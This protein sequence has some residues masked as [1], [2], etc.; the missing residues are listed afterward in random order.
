M[1]PKSTLTLVGLSHRTCPVTVR[2]RY[3][4]SQADLPA[5]LASLLQIDGVTEAFVLSTCNRTEALVVA[6]RG[7]DVAA[8]VRAQLFRNLPDEHVYVYTDV[9]ALIHSFRVA[10]GLDS[11][12]VG[13]S[14]VLAQIKRGSDAAQAAKTVGPVL[15]PLIQQ[16][17]HVGKRV[18]S[19]TEVGQGTLSV[20]RVG[21]DVAS[22]V[23][24]TFEDE[25]ALV[26]GAG[27]T[28]VLVARHLKEKKIGGL[29][30]ANRTL[31]R[32]QNAAAE[33]GATAHGLD[34]L[35]ALILRSDLIVACV[36]GQ[37]AVI[38]ASVFDKRAI[39]RRDK[40]MLVIDLSVPRAVAADVAELDHNILLYDLDDLSR[41]VNENEKGRQRAVD[42][43]NEILVTELH[44]F[45]SLR[46]YATFSPAIAVL[47]ERFEKVRE[48]VLDHVAGARSDP[49]DV[50][51]A[52]ELT[53][54]LLDVAL[55][56]MKESARHT[57]S[58]E[59]LDR[60]YQRFLENL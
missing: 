46:T 3:V 56:Q 18:R 32:A 48:D 2:E 30:F 16:S 28:G 21:I 19:E 58:E 39:K 10:S 4:V 29:A 53:R 27:E 60:E 26:I 17:L 59:A 37:T 8:R 14:E 34:E 5:C 11:L 7:V 51:L 44:K 38:D 13:E 42:G 33:F 40:P 20:A 36:E 55:D 31:E 22:R 54:K 47:R 24:G 15:R 49:K 12:V 1:D 52:H 6:P 9:H 43:T 23:F 25:R 45:L 57:R 50:Q 41:V 35:P